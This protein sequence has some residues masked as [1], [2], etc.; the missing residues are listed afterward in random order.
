M[1]KLLAFALIVAAI[2]CGKSPNAEGDAA[3]EGSAAKGTPPINGNAGG[4]DTIRPATPGSA[5][6]P[7]AP[8]MGSESVGGAGMG[9][10]GQA[11]KDQARNAAG[12]AGSGSLGGDGSGDE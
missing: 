1:R 12:A 9:G 10:L 2:G 7:N 8:V 11:A 5:A 4:N 6:I 3:T